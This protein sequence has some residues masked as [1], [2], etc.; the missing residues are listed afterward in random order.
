MIF[1]LVRR[2]NKR[3]QRRREAEAKGTSLNG[4]HDKK[5]P[6]TADGADDADLPTMAPDGDTAASAENEY[7]YIADMPPPPYPTSADHT[8]NIQQMTSGV[9]PVGAYERA[10]AARVTKDPRSP[11]HMPNGAA[12]GSSP[13]SPRPFTTFGHR[14]NESFDYNGNDSLQ[15]S[16]SHGRHE[17]SL[18]GSPLHTGPLHSSPLHGTNSP[19][20]SLHNSPLHG[21][22]TEHARSDSIGAPGRVGPRLL[23]HECA[24]NAPRE[25][26]PYNMR[27]V[28]TRSRQSGDG[29]PDAPTYFEVDPDRE[30]HY[31]AAASPAHV[32]VKIASD[33]RQPAMTLPNGNVPKNSYVFVDKAAA[34]AKL[35]GGKNTL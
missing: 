16:P 30:R 2:L 20:H 11:R 22:R 24:L 18:N 14:R 33:P 13:A 17:G 7:A 3:A 12:A 25:P 4:I 29:M 8:K 23:A 21:G 34:A 10:A 19:L 27:K 35:A 31:H 5:P 28:R 9:Y 26:S 6:R 32:H 15:D 1:P